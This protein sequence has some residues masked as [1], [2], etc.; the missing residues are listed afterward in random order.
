MTDRVAVVGAGPAGLAAGEALLRGGRE[1]GGRPYAALMES[2]L[3]RG[4]CA[5]AA[6]LG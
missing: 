3:R 2:A 5:A 4:R 6:L 1:V